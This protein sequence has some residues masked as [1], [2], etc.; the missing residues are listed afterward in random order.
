MPRKP[1][2]LLPNHP[3]HI[4]QAGHNSSAVFASPEDYLFYLQQLKHQRQA[5]GFKL[6]AWCLMPG[7]VNLLIEPG[8]DVG[9]ISKLMKAQA[10]MQARFVNQRTKRRGTLWEGRFRCS[11][12]QRQDYLLAC[13]H[14]IER[15]PITAGLVSLP[16]AYRWN[17]YLERSGQEL[18]LP[19]DSNSSYH[20]LA[21]TNTKRLQR[22]RSYLLSDGCNVEACLIESSL[23]RNQPT[24]GAEFAEAISKRLGISLANRGP[25]RPR[26][27]TPKE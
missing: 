27:I 2:L 25:G 3:H 7:S 4:F 17:S 23:R 16:E 20:S 8:Q 9:V 21:G 12:V 26:K 24:G 11:P 6:Y 15:L 14:Y 22:Y 18:R 5:L 13:M 10:S 1:R 19:L